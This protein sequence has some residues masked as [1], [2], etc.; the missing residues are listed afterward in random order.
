MI[1]DDL[2]TLSDATPRV[3]T[4]ARPQGPVTL[5]AERQRL[6]PS[7][8][9][10]ALLL[11]CVMVTLTGC[12]TDM[13]RLVNFGPVFRGEAFAKKETTSKTDKSGK[14]RPALPRD[15][16]EEPD[17]GKSSKEL[18]ASKDKSA[19]SET[20]KEVSARDKAA[21]GLARFTQRK[22]AATE[23]TDP[24]LAD[25]KATKTRSVSQSKVKS[26]A[27]REPRE[28]VEP[29][30]EAAPATAKKPKVARSDLPSG[31]PGD[32]ERRGETIDRL[33]EDLA[34][35]R[36]P[37][38]GIGEN[39]PFVRR[40]S[41]RQVEG[42]TGSDE[43]DLLP[44][45][46]GIAKRP[47]VK[48]LPSSVNDN[49]LA[50]VRSTP[51]INPRPI[52]SDPTTTPGGAGPDSATGTA[53]SPSNTAGPVVRPAPSSTPNPAAPGAPGT[54]TDVP[55]INPGAQANTPA[56]LTPTPAAPA[57]LPS[58]AGTVPAGAPS[59]PGSSA[60]VATPLTNPGIPAGPT[61][62][63]P[64][65]PATPGP[66]PGEP[67]PAP[68]PSIATPVTPAPVNPAVPAPAVPAP[69]VPSLGT[70]G[71]E[72]AS[73]A[74]AA[75]NLGTPAPATPAPATPAAPATTVPAT[76]APA[77]T[78]PNPTATPVATNAPGSLAPTTPAAT[79][80]AAPVALAPHV[81]TTG[82]TLVA[83]PPP[84]TIDPARLVPKHLGSNGSGARIDGGAYARNPAHVESPL[85]DPAAD[86][87]TQQWSQR[88]M[89]AAVGLFLG[90]AGML[91]LA[92]W[93]FVERRYYD[94][95]RRPTLHTP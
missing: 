1:T 20:T 37:E 88:S 83:P 95:P 79:P 68:A 78:V 47:A 89:I 17:A 19:K 86:F 81:E 12:Q 30:D 34:K 4:L 26:P 48:K 49:S 91:G 43:V 31:V 7:A 18:V 77:L 27:E 3:S 90:V 32:V 21:T 33:K 93:T 53:P 41:V 5:C 70:S 85:Y 73:S 59:A 36:I 65:A 74:P 24:F 13:R 28:T 61:S 2:P 6:R 62:P 42:E 75:P 29:T 8:R 66:N 67:A 16:E 55:A 52:A 71:L 50:D 87:L 38:D 84:L 11:A 44:P 39:S 56:T 94:H 35:R 57:G 15:D 80:A 63:I 46:G 22:P 60:P 40:G 23:L 9:R 76:S 82:P 72:T 51:R 25:E 10:A 54:A 64:G 14:T 45:P 58:T 92:I 69:G